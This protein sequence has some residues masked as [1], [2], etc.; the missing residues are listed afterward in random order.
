MGSNFFFAKRD[1][2]EIG[3]MNRSPSK[4]DEE[5]TRKVECGIHIGFQG[6]VWVVTVMH[7]LVFPA[8]KKK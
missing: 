4:R 8:R 5:I 1:S 6:T 3:E 2:L 7:V